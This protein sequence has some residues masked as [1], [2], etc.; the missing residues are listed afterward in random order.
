[1]FHCIVKEAPCAEQV[2]FTSHAA[3]RILGYLD[4]LIVVFAR[5]LSE[6]L[7]SDYSE[8]QHWRRTPVITVNQCGGIRIFVVAPIGDWDEGTS[9]D[10]M[11][12]NRV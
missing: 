11:K 1:M 12:D 6:Q 7:E 9:S 8:T 3:R 5:D 4:Y 2:F 10:A